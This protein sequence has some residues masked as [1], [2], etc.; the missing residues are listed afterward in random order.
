MRF[1]NSCHQLTQI[2]WF[3]QT[4]LLVGKNVL[5]YQVAACDL[6]TKYPLKS[7]HLWLSRIQRNCSWTYFLL[8]LGDT[9][10]RIHLQTT[11]EKIS[12]QHQA[13]DGVYKVK[14]QLAGRHHQK[15]L[16][17]DL[18]K[19]KHFSIYWPVSFCTHEFLYDLST[20]WL[21]QCIFKCWSISYD[22]RPFTNANFALDQS[23]VVTNFLI[24]NS[25]RHRKHGLRNT[26]LA[27]ASFEEF[28]RL[29]NWL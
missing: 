9:G 4:N 16:K 12:C 26:C 27:P 2:Q 13:D 29:S 5:I 7:N 10:E 17:T 18:S 14:T 20:V 28:L 8:R 24:I 11:A 21:G 19:V 22:T 15:A 3:K 25:H 1:L 6:H 23:R